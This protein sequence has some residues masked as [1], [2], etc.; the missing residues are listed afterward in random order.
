VASARSAGRITHYWEVFEQ[1][2]LSGDNTGQDCPRNR[3]Q[4]GHPG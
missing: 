1:F 2:C 4:F 3:E